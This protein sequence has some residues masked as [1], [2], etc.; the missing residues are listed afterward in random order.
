MGTG[1]TIAPATH[2]RPDIM[3]QPVSR[4]KRQG[5]STKT[6]NCTRGTG[7]P[8]RRL[9]PLPFA[10]GMDGLSSVHDRPTI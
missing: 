2:D 6:V 7:P 4:I 5:H 1:P 9:R 10:A 8:F 3:A